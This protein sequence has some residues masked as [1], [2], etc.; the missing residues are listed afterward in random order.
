MS[1]EIETQWERFRREQR[2]SIE[3]GEICSSCHRYVAIVFPPGHPQ[4]CVFCKRLENPESTQHEKYIRCPNCKFHWDPYESENY[5]VLQDGCH[6]VYCG[7][8]DHKFEI[9]TSV[10]H[11]FHNPKCL[12]GEGEC[13]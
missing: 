4:K 10:I 3:K 9:V 5:A 11:T 2:E 8:C 1:D 12:A 6:E 13:E 7:E